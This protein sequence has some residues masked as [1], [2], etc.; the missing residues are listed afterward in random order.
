V[1]KFIKGTSSERTS[2]NSDVL[3]I[4]PQLEPAAITRFCRIIRARHSSINAL[5]EKLSSL[6]QETCSKTK[7]LSDIKISTEC[8]NHSDSTFDCYNRVPEGRDARH[9]RLL[10]RVEAPPDPAVWLKTSSV[11]VEALIRKYDTL[12]DE[13]K[14]E[15]TAVRSRLL[16]L[17]RIT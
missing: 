12:I 15:V 9:Q 16:S 2:S 8:N 17:D 11:P 14:L 1:G 13:L 7:N 10:Q 5:Q 4:I 6:L 3:P